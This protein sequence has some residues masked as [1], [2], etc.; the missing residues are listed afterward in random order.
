MGNF[1][2]NHSDQQDDLYKV[3]S[4]Q[5]IKQFF[6]SRGE[7]LKQA[8]NSL[9]TVL[10]QTVNGDSG[11]DNIKA[12]PI[13]DLSGN[14]VQ[15]ILQSIRNALK[16]TTVNSS[17]ADFIKSSGISGVTGDTVQKLLEGLKAIA[18]NLQEQITTNVTDISNLQNNK[19]DKT[20][21]Y[22]KAQ[23]DGGQLDNRYYNKTELQSTADG[24]SGADK[25]KATPIATSP[26]TV[27]GIL[28]WLKSQIDQ[29][30]AGTIPDGSLTDVKLG[31][32]IKIGSLSNLVTQNKTSVVSAVNEVSQSI[33]SHKTDY[34]SHVPYAVASGS[35]NAYAVTLSPAPSA[36]VEGMA[37]AVKINVQN[38]GASTLNVNGLGAKSIKKANGNDVAAGNL[39]AGSIYTLR[40]NGTNFILQGEGGG[41]T[42]QPGDV[43]SG[44][45][46]TND[47]GEQS[48]TMVNRGAVNQTITTQGGQF[49]IPAG[50][51]NGQGKVTANFANL[52][53]G[54]I[55]KGVNVGGVVGTVVERIAK[56]FILLAGI[57][58]LGSPIDWTP[59]VESV[60]SGNFSSMT[61]GGDVYGVSMNAQNTSG[62]S[63]YETISTNIPI[64]L[65]N[66]DVIHFR[67]TYRKYYESMEQGGACYIGVT[68]NKDDRQTS[69]LVK[70]QFTPAFNEKT[71][72]IYMNVGHLTGNFY[73]KAEVTNDGGSTQYTNLR[74][75]EITLIQKNL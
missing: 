28:E 23:L 4:A 63:S 31:P 45:T 72:D 55:K 11:A 27:Q 52:T 68:A 14:T 53:A 18:D 50:Y 70:Q 67:G 66:I 19:A 38:T 61:K 51:H 21:I 49:T 32:D 65:T 13:S 12:T 25:I 15:A 1:S 5:E 3:Y 48:G 34:A 69:Y 75:D 17:G 22:T 16:S 26:D 43:L 39:K 6:D 7:E 36:Y 60:K 10:Q 42:A 33:S 58:A 35:A 41:G 40:F 74:I 2:F 8:L 62:L 57:Q 24:N 30:T 37:L 54:N 47:D 44:K 73:I 46:F 56:P 20:S 59:I 9:I 71:Y 29:A 64:D